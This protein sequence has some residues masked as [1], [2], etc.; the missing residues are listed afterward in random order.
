MAKATETAVFVHGL[1]MTGLELGL[2]RYRVARAGFR[3]RRFR[4]RSLAMPVYEN[5]ARLKAYLA[6]IETDRLHLIG[7]SLGGLVILRMFEAGVELPPGRV[8][9]MG[10]PVR[11]SLAALTLMQR[12]VGW[13]LGR[14]ADGALV[15]QHEPRWV[16]PR[17]LGLITGTH[18]FSLNPFHALLPSPNDGMVAEEETRIEGTKDNARVYANHTGMLFSKELAELVS[19][20]LQT[21]VFRR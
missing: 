14:S 3:T 6:S 20:F 16:W 15:G 18:E 8:I 1:Y 11:G 13:L 7:H 17:D 5:A 9:F 2:L 12:R 4:Y 21:G 10:S 19:A